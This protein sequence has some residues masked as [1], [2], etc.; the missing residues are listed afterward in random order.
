MFLDTVLWK[1]RFDMVCKYGSTREGHKTHVLGTRN[2]IEKQSKPDV[3]NW[4]DCN[5]MII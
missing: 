2:I 3:P 4:L 5:L 1:V